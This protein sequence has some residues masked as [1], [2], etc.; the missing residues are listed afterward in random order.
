MTNQ[1]VIVFVF[2]F[3]FFKSGFVFSQTSNI[4]QEL[5]HY[6]E[7]VF[8][9]GQV[10]TADSDTPDFTVAQAVAVRGNR[11]LKV[12]SDTEIRRL[13]GPATRSIDL[14]GRSLTPGFVY[15]DGDNSV[16]AGDLI[17]DS[18]WGGRMQPKLGGGTI[19]QALL[20]LGHIVQTQGQ[21]GEA[22]VL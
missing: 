17:K 22:H 11:I 20:T 2:S 6:P 19:D 18:Q 4:P 8:Y 13:A 12:G 3:L 9:N 14:R 10:L 21:P 15:N 1:K 7:Y 16:P 5:V